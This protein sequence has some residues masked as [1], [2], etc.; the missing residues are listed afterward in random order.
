MAVL[1]FKPTPFFAN[2]NRAFWN[3][4]LT[5]WGAAFLLRALSAL[6]N[7]QPLDLLVVILVTTITGFSISLVLS[8]IYRRLIN[9]RPVVTWG[10]TALVLLAAVVAIVVQVGIYGRIG[11]TRILGV[12]HVLWLPMFVWIAVRSGQVV[13]DPALATWLVL[14]VSTNVACLIVDTLDVL[15]FLRGERAPH[16]KWARA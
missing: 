5:G 15:R 3:L 12:S 6:A 11:F 16:Y 13:Y 9:E 4:Q 8:V 1:P 2:K 10:V 7:G 14:V